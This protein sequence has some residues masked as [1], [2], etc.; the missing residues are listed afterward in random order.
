MAFFNRFVWI[1]VSPSRVFDEIKEGAVSWWQPWLWV[2]IIYTI[3]GYFSLPVQRAVLELNPR[4]TPPDQL[5]QQIELMDKFGVV[6]LLAT[7]VVFLVLGLIVAG[8]AYIL[9]SILSEKASFKKFLTLQFYAGI[10]SALSGIV[11]VL[12]VRM[13]GVETFRV[14]EDAQFSIGLGF[15]APENGGLLKA[16]LGSVEFFAVW[17]LVIVAM[18]LMQVFDMQRKQAVICVI[19]I[20]LMSVLALALGNFFG[21]VS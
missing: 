17:S 16:V 19:P 3:V 6:Q 12:V 20:W 2:S 4:G 11:T 8:L 5:D 1:L 13:R 9:V 21:G 10:I 15:L 14:A 18:G 7:P